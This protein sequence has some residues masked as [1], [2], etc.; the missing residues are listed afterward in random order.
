MAGNAGVPFV[1]V[2]GDADEI[3]D[4]GGGYEGRVQPEWKRRYE[5]PGKWRPL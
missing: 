5:P 3:I 2:I 4:D 1:A